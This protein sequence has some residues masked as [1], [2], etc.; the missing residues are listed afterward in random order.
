MGILCCKKDD[1]SGYDYQCEHCA[2]KL[3]PKQ[4]VAVCKNKVFC[5]DI[6]KNNFIYNEHMNSNPYGFVS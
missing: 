4:D 1:Y 3:L 5:S 2:E 6:C